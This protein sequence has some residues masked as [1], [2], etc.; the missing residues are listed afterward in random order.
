MAQNVC[1]LEEKNTYV[2][3]LNE[4]QGKSQII[5]FYFG[6]EHK[7]LFAFCSLQHWTELQNTFCGVVWNIIYFA[8]VFI[9]F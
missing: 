6:M 1:Q 9:L 2:Q 4:Y 8:H 5:Y 7:F 3:A